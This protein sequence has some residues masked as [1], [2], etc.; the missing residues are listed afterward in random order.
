MMNRE[1]ASWSR[2]LS[3]SWY[4]ALCSL[5]LA[6]GA[7]VLWRGMVAAATVR[8]DLGDLRHAH[9]HVMLV[10]WAS[11]A[12]MLLIAQQLKERGAK[13]SRAA[14]S[15]TLALLALSALASLPTFALWGYRS[16]EIGAARVPLSIIASTINML[17]W[18]A[19]AAIYWSA[20]RGQPRDSA[21]WCLDAAVAALVAATFG[22][23]GRGA[24][25]AAH[26]DSPAL[27]SVM[28]HAL[29]DTFSEGWL[30]LGLLGLWAHRARIALPRAARL[31]LCVGVASCCLLAPAPGV[32][33][34]WLRAAIAPAGVALG[35]TWVVVA[36][37]LWS[38][39]GSLGSLAQLP[40]ALLGVKGLMLAANA[41]PW[42]S[43]WG[44][45][46]GMRILY[47]HIAL[48][49]VITLGLLERAATLRIQAPRLPLYA[50]QVG[51]LALLI[52]IAALTLPWG[53]T[54][55]GALAGALVA[56]TCLVWGG[57]SATPR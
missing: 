27:A 34:G 7:G 13:I 28:V 18:Y 42:V 1:D 12:L 55:W 20:R 17:G 33:P 54:L 52:S 5:L 14:L 6:A 51:A 40:V 41:L 53:L 49:G 29:V 46:H 19:F 31:A 2:L 39:R 37:A 22:G 15:A 50:A 35:L 11:P 21:A 23:W 56:A 25:L 38:R 4:A 24:L 57:V 47:L 8:L 45:A 26:V 48:V 3:R 43:A 44:H 36:G 10:G 9:S 30:M 32:L 16:A